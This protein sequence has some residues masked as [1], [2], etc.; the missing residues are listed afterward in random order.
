MESIAEMSMGEK[1]PVPNLDKEHLIFVGS[2]L[3]DR[4]V[5]HKRGVSHSSLLNVQ[6]SV[7]RDRGPTE[8]KWYHRRCQISQCF[9]LIA[10][11]L[12]QQTVP[13]GP[14]Q[15]SPPTTPAVLP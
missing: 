1:L 14:N 15:N 13:T 12:A 5:G 11:Y 6:F 8:D 7:F 10:S 3:V 4:I 2:Y 9:E